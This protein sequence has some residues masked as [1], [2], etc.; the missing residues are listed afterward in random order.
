MSNR[1]VAV[2]SFWQLARH[3]KSGGKAKLELTCEDGS[4][5]MHLST[6]LGHPDHPHF[7]HPP[8]PH[9]PHPPPFHPIPKKN[10]SPS[11][12]RRQEQ[13]RKEALAKATEAFTNIN[14]I[15]EEHKNKLPIDVSTENMSH[16]NE[17]E[18]IIEAEVG[19]LLNLYIF[20]SNVINVITQTH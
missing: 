15:I 7:P 5:Q 8:P 4:L 19:K 9:L 3:W 20:Y 12:L 10:K 6:V 1:D 16:V 18:I 14:I 11:Q 13:R 17:A 2:S